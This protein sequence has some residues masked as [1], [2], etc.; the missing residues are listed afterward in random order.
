MSKSVRRWLTV[1]VLTTALALPA[2]TAAD[3]ADTAFLTTNLPG[4]WK[5]WLGSG[6]VEIGP[7]PILLPVQG[8]VILGAGIAGTIEKGGF[9]IAVVSPDGGTIA[10]TGD[11]SDET[12]G[13]GTLVTT[14]TAGNQ[15]D[16]VFR[17]EKFTPT[18]TMELSG[19]ISGNDLAHKSTTAVGAL[20]SGPGTTVADTV[21]VYSI[22]D[23]RLVEL[24]FSTAN[25]P[26]KGEV[27]IGTS[28]GRVLAV[29]N[30]ATL[31]G[32]GVGTASAGTLK[33]VIFDSAGFAADYQIVVGASLLTGRFS[34]GYDIVGGL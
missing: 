32:Y 16:G 21:T 19:S 1:P 25:M 20:Y 29:V 6:S 27:G 10:A 3:D 31:D 8:K 15:T 17:M 33:N 14:D 11:L 12:H 5:V 18:G 4:Y 34:V 7:L 13:S 28:A 26:E 24:R 22:S 9:R 30:F 23:N 2:C